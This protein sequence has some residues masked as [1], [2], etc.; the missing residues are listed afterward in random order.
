[1]YVPKPELWN[2]KNMRFGLLNNSS[3]APYKLAEKELFLDSWF[4]KTR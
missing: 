1:M 4:T 3:F 2:E